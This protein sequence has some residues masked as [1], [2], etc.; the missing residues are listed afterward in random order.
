MVTWVP[1]KIQGP[2][3]TYK[4]STRLQIVILKFIAW[5]YLAH[6]F[7]LNRKLYIYVCTWLCHWWSIIEY[8]FLHPRA[9]RPCIWTQAFIYI[10]VFILFNWVHF[11]DELTLDRAIFG[12]NHFVIDLVC[13]LNTRFVHR[14]L[15]CLEHLTW[16]TIFNKELNETVNLKAPSRVEMG[17]QI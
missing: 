13:S 8:V 10:K 17:E 9:L 5:T 1:L 11:I 2:Q 6:Y 12:A 15:G 14:Y 3:D 7:M 4:S 16:R